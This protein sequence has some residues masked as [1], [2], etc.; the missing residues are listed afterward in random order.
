[1]A[2]LNAALQLQKEAGIT[3]TPEQQ[4]QLES[5]L[6]NK[7]ISEEMAKEDS[8]ISAGA[9]DAPP[10]KPVPPNE[11]TAKAWRMMEAAGVYVEAEDPEARLVDMTSDESYLNTIPAA[12]NAKKY[13]LEQ[14]SVPP[15]TPPISAGSFGTPTHNSIESVDDPGE[16]WDRAK[17]KK[18]NLTGGSKWLIR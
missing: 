17:A 16:L 10:D 8:G 6:R 11:T 9:T 15:P 4:A 2:S 7:I 1:V 14:G 3:V 18:Q 12:I 13:R 5:N